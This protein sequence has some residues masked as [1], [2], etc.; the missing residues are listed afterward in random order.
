MNL[1]HVSNVVAAHVH[2]STRLLDGEVFIVSDDDAPKT[3]FV[4]GIIADAGFGRPLSTVPRVPVPLRVLRWILTQA[5]GRN[6][7]NPLTRYSSDK[8]LR[9]DSSARWAFAR[10]GGL[11]RLVSSEPIWAR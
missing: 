2:G 8:L 3:I 11:C 9:L 10:V 4:G 1:V 6:N 5:M 7:V